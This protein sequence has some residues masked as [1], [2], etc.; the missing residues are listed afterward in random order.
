MDEDNS[1]DRR[2]AKRVPI[3]AE[4]AEQLPSATYVSDLS[5]GGVFVHTELEVEVG[6]ELDVR[7][8]AIVEDPI[9]VTARGR[10]VRRSDDPPGVGIEFTDVDPEMLGRIGQIV[11]GLDAAQGEDAPS[12]ST[13]Q[14]RIEARGVKLKLRRADSSGEAGVVTENPGTS[15][16]SESE[17]TLMNLKA[18][19]VEIIDDEPDGEDEEEGR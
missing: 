2:R 17:T 19:D 5:E 16:E 10:V 14:G 4:F 7:F 9:L 18:V 15:G 13:S 12:A 3:N 11:D 8:T 6:M 1:G